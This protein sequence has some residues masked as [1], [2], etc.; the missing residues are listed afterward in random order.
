[1]QAELILLHRRTL[2][3]CRKAFVNQK[4]LPAEK[5]EKILLK[6]KV[7]TNLTDRFTTE[8]TFPNGEE[9]GD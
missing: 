8:C 9:P 1:M 5:G 6:L 7:L 2:I 3:C 4:A